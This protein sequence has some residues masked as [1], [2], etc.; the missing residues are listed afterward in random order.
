MKDSTAEEAKMVE[1]VEDKTPTVTEVMPKFLFLGQTEEVER[2]TKY[3]K[4]QKD[5]SLIILSKDEMDLI[6]ATRVGKQKQDEVEAFLD[7]DSHKQRA[8][9]L[10]TELYGRFKIHFDKGFVAL[11]AVKKQTTLSW[12]GFNEVIGTLDMFGFIGWSTD[13]KAIQI[14]LE[15]GKILDNKRK[16]I[17]KTLDFARGQILAFEKEAGASVDKKVV[18]KLKK[19]LVVNF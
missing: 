8:E 14:L 11:G 12:K 15:P 1:G 9:S 2:I 10:A 19:S 4:S 17:Q 16:E 7:N 6:V 3:M 13:R 5:C 18:D